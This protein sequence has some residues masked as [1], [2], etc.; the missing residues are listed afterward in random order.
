MPGKAPPDPGSSIDSWSKLAPAKQ[1]SYK[2]NVMLARMEVDGRN[3]LKAVNLFLKAL[4]DYFQTDVYKQTVQTIRK[5]PRNKQRTYLYKLGKVLL[6]HSQ[7]PELAQDTL[8]KLSILDPSYLRPVQKILMMH[9]D[10]NSIAQKQLRVIIRESAVKP[11]S[12]TDAHREAS[13][14]S[15]NKSV[16][17]ELQIS[18]EETGEHFTLHPDQTDSTQIDKDTLDDLMDSLL[19]DE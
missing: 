11:V 15:K 6:I 5:L 13:T 17:S 14:P 2:L 10:E 18:L 12:P 9:E 8:N 16:E 3:Y 1:T 4:K 19:S 7:Q